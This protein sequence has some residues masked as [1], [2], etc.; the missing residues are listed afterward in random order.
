MSM[1]KQGARAQKPILQHPHP[2]FDAAELPAELL[3]A[4]HV[5]YT[6]LHALHLSI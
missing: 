6:H 2:E 1:V 3:E 5:V 4:H